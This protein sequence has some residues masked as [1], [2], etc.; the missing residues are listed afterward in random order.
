MLALRARSEGRSGGHWA[1]TTV[2]TN[3]P[4]KLPRYPT[5][6]SAYGQVGHGMPQPACSLQAGGRG[7][8]SPSSTRSE[9]MLI[10]VKITKRLPLGAIGSLICP[11]MT[12]W[13]GNLSRAER[14]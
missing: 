6:R 7:F 13:A 9:G 5:L 11:L 8:E 14:H 1:L 12:V 4:D 3:K 10:S 2:L